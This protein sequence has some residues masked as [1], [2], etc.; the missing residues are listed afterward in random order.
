[1]R[2]QFLR[3]SKL[4]FHQLKIENVHMRRR[5]APLFIFSILFLGQLLLASFTPLVVVR[6]QAK[7]KIAGPLTVASQKQ[8]DM[9]KGASGKPL[10][11]QPNPMVDPATHKPEVK[12]E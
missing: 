10:K 12:E 9:E 7:A 2:A 6:A 5:R 4:F 3:G 11:N 1:M 8:S